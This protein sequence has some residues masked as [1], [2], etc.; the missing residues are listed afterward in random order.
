MSP[1]PA[2]PQEG[3][4]RLSPARVLDV[5]PLLE[6]PKTRIVVCCGSGGVGKTTTAAALGLRAAERGRKVVVLTI[7][8]ARRLAQSMGIDSLDNTPRRVKGVDDSAGGEL[9]AMMLDMKR[10]FD[11]IVEA[12]ADPGR[13]AAILGNP[14]YQS[15]SAGFA[16]TQEY[17]AMEK[18][19]QLRAR[20]EWDL[21]VVDTPPSRS[22]LDFLDAPKRLGS[23]LDGKLI[24]LLLAP[25]KVGGRAGMKFLNVGMSMMTGVLGKVLGGQFLKDVQT[26]VAAMDSMFGGFRTRADATYKLLQAPG[27]AFLVVAAPERDALREA[28]YFV[29]R[30]AAEDMPLAGLVLNRV[31]GSDADRLSAE[32]ALAAAENLEDRRIVDQDG[33]KAG[34]RNSPD[35]QGSSDAPEP[36]LSPATAPE[37]DPSSETDL[38]PETEHASETGPASGSTP[39]PRPSADAPPEAADAPE[40]SVDQLAAGLL[41]LHADRMHLLAREQRTRDRFTARHPEVAV[42]E[43][44][45]LPGD[46]HDLAG[47][48][49]IGDRLATSRPELPEPGA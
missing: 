8:P 35:V 11:E 18:L 12:H 47:L 14:F 37:A 32:R 23:F 25:A 2:R 20:D 27:T 49:D 16:G 30:L 9:H 15:L 42:T 26:F 6:D 43:V 48:R 5:D 45:A 22:A 36:S 44:A 24:R 41:R 4:R 29:E 19:G 7:D 34:V 21:I 17:M 33:G 31:H 1:D 40:R 13:A 28:A 3:A 46:V 10:T 38:A 39:E